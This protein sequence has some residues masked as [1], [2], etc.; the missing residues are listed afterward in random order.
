[1][2]QLLHAPEIEANEAVLT[3]ADRNG[4]EIIKAAVDRA[5]VVGELAQELADISQM[6]PGSYAMYSG[7][8]TERLDP[9]KTLDD[10]LAGQREAAVRLLPELTGN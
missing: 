9:T 2:D 3:V 1:M 4:R 8:G 6:P 5:K 7:D 10:N